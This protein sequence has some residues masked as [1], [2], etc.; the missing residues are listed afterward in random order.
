MLAR[1]GRLAVRHGAAGSGGGSLAAAVP[2][3]VLGFVAMAAVRTAGDSLFAGG[4]SANEWRAGMDWLGGVLGTKVLLGT[5]LAAVGLSVDF[6][7]FRGVGLMPFAVGGA[8]ASIVGGVGL[9]VA[10]GLSRL[11]PGGNSVVAV[12]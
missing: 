9:A 3:F 1:V 4:A 7:A 5:G 6:A 11:G 12:A 8:G 2:A 10:L